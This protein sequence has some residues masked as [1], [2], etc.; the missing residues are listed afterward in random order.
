[1]RGIPF[2]L[3]NSLLVKELGPVFSRDTKSKS[4]GVVNKNNDLGKGIGISG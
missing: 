4:P 2:P 1:M 3:M